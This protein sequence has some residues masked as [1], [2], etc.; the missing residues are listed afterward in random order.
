MKTEKEILLSKILKL[1]TKMSNIGVQVSDL[2][3]E[4]SSKFSPYKIGDKVK[5][6][7]NDNKIEFGKIERYWFNTK[8][9][10]FIVVRLWN[11][12]FTQELKRRYPVNCNNHMAKHNSNYSKFE[13]L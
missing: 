13:L 9:L 5:V 6:I 7:H 10:W 4:Y 8:G 2:C 1:E 3:K 12:D 11:K